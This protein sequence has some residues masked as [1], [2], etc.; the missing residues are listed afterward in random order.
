[1]AEARTCKFK[2]QRYRGS[3]HRN[4]NCATICVGEGFTVGKCHGFLFKCWCKS[5]A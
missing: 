3:C 4:T 1:M 5:H 2:S